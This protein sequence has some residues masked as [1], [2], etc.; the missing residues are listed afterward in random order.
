MKKGGGQFRVFTHKLMVFDSVH[1]T[2]SANKHGAGP[3]RVEIARFILYANPWAI[4][5][6]YITKN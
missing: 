5:N 2:I 3:M 6:L 4:R 1:L